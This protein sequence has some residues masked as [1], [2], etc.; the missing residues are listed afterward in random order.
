[1]TQLY[2]IEVKLT[3]HK[4]KKFSDAFSKREKIV[5]RLS[6]DAL[7]GNDTFCVVKCCEK[8]SQKSSIMKGHGY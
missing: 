8:I 4:K 2:Q 7:T 5:L 3:A 1:M 6:K